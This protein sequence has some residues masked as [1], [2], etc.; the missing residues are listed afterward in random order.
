MNWTNLDFQLKPGAAAIDAGVVIP[1]FTDG[2]LGS[3]PDLGA[4]ESGG[5]AWA[6]GVGSRPALAFSSVGGGSLTLTASP[7]AAY[8]QLCSTTNLTSTALWIPVATAPSMSGNQWSITLPISD[9]Q[10]CYYRLQGL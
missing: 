7:D 2:Y 3:A 5:L 6:A 1:G 4:Y 9:S 10:S 8:Y